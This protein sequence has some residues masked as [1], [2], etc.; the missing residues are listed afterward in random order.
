MPVSVLSVRPSQARPSEALREYCALAASCSRRRMAVL[1]PVGESDGRLIRRP[2]DSSSC[3]RATRAA[4]V[5]IAVSERST[6][7]R[8]V[9]L[10][11]LIS[12]S[13]PSC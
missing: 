9:I 11:V 6:I 8:W 2:V 7:W 4:L 10:M 12:G 5:C 13:A 1:V 3:D